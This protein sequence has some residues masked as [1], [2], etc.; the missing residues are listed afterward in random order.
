MKTPNLSS[1]PTTGP[2]AGRMPGPGGPRPW[3]S[4]KRFP[5]SAEAGSGP[6]GLC[7]GREPWPLLCEARKAESLSGP[8]YRSAWE[9][10]VE[11]G[12]THDPHEVTVQLDGAGRQLDE[13]LAR[14]VKDAQDAGAG[15]DGPVFVDETGRRSRRYRRIGMVVGV[16]CAVYAVVIVATLLSGNS[17]AP[18]LPVPGQQDEQPAG[19]VETDPLPA[20]SVAPSDSVGVT[21]AAP[22]ASVSA[23]VPPSKGA[24]AV[25]PG[26]SPSAASPGTSVAPVPSAGAGKPEPGTPTTPGPQ[27]EP[28]VPVSSPPPEPSPSQS[29]LPSPDPSPSPSPSTSPATDGGTVADGRT[30]PTPI[31]EGPA[32]PSATLAAG[33]PASTPA[34]ATLTA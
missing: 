15:G 21:P 6:P 27:P 5:G 19:Q 24:A 10:P 29:G 32:E 18:W 25:K 31:A 2:R 11:A 28:S 23:G 26:A 12:H 3:R 9:N 7:P 1:V 17:D 22:G 16:S 30:D 34:P 14:Q 13:P 8:S 20:E 33:D 4:R